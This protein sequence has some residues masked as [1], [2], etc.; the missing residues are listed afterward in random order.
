M[1]YKKLLEKFSRIILVEEIRR[2]EE[3]ARRN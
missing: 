3:N 2:E 1:I